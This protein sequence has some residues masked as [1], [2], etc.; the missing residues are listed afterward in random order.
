MYQD[1][2]ILKPSSEKIQTGANQTIK[3]PSTNV[4]KQLFIFDQKN[5]QKSE[6][7][8]FKDQ[9]HLINA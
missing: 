8:F 2:R 1:F 9:A 6:K 7:K 5:S 4:D 3:P